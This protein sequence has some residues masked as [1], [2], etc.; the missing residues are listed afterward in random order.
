MATVLVLEPKL[1]RQTAQAYSLKVLIVEVNFLL[2]NI[3]KSSDP[4]S[5]IMQT[6]G[7]SWLTGNNK[8]VTI[9]Y[10]PLSLSH[11]L[12]LHTSTHTLS[13]YFFLSPPLP[14]SLTFFAF[15]WLLW[16]SSVSH[17]DVA[18]KTDESFFLTLHPPENFF[19]LRWQKDWW[20]N[21]FRVATAPGRGFSLGET[22]ARRTCK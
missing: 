19:E 4:S 1:A 9:F 10:L 8:S 13:V 11:S 18:A 17:E 2:A 5:F 20:S 15:L 16:H 7:T 3:L 14:L 12:S 22:P 6:L 21:P